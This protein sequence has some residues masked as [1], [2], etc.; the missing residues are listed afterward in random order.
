MCIKTVHLLLCGFLF[1]SLLS[2]CGR[3]RPDSLTEDTA[4]DSMVLADSVLIDSLSMADNAPSEDETA[5]LIDSA[6]EVTP[7]LVNRT[8]LRIYI[9]KPAMRLF[10]VNNSDSVVFSCG[11]ACGI[12]K[13]DKTGKG[14]YRTPEG[15]FS[16]SGMFNST[17]WIHHTRDGRSVKGCY[18]PRFLR[19][20][21]GRFS[22]IGIHGTNA[23]G[24][25]G[26]RA[27]E[28][29]IRVNSANIMTI[30]DDYAYEGMPVVVSTEDA[31]LPP[32]K[33]LPEECHHKNAKSSISEMPKEPVLKDDEK[34]ADTTQTRPNM[35]HSA[36][37][38]ENVDNHTEEHHSEGDSI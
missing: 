30:F 2:S 28:G 38:H 9:S 17:D 32:F 16:I 14:D 5:A 19:L 10:V 31:P 25:I 7:A 11:I 3:F 29:C 36:E 18:G 1:F 27:S 12:R 21:T 26:R 23:P 35:E 34:V 8:G 24:S 20:R 15:D 4:S 22:G 33:G 37:V 13:G 6:K